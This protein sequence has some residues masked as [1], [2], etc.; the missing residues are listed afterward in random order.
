MHDEGVAWG[1]SINS[2][3]TGN[4]GGRAGAQGGDGQHKQGTGPG[5]D[6]SPL[7]RS[8]GEEGDGAPHAMRDAKK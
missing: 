6:I 7:R 1:F 8:E 2:G 4:P 5:N 3:T